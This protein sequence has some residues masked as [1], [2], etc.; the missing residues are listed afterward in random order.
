MADELAQLR[1][2]VARQADEIENLRRQ[3]ADD[4]FGRRL[5]EVF[6]LAATAGR[7]AAPV[8][9]SELLQMIVRT[10]ADVISARAASLF[11]V[12]EAAG[13]LVAERP[14]GPGLGE[15]DEIRV[16]LGR[17]IA[18]LVASTGQPMAIS[19]VQADPRHASDIARRIG[20]AP[21]SILCVPLI[22]N[23]EVVGV[24]ELLD[25]ESAPSFSPSDMET[26]GLIA[27][28]AA[29]AVEQS[30]TLQSLSALIAE[31]LH[32]VDDGTGEQLRQLHEAARAFAR[33]LEEIPSYR[34]ALDLGRLI[35]EISAAGEA[36]ATACQAILRG[37][38][39]YL[40]ARPASLADLDLVR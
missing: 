17:G 23:E 19:D 34:R 3:L 24:F 40:R 21:K 14:I 16:P 4:E 5:R 30:R 22:Y 35:Q 13:E 36:E 20:Y 9:H 8:A 29:V 2:T 28:H 11:L 38:A 1:E 26:L 15:L 39:D 32:L 10:A 12:D 37:F 31:V 7:I 18:G 25:K 6:S 33:R 27:N